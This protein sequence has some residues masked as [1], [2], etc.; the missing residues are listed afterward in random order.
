MRT[1]SFAARPPATPGNKPACA[2]SICSVAKTLPVSRSKTE[3]NASAPRANTFPLTITGCANITTSDSVSSILAFQSCFKGKSRDK[4][5]PPCAEV[6]PG[7][8]NPLFTTAF[9]RPASSAEAC[10]S[11]INVRRSESTSSRSPDRRTSLSAQP[12]SAN[13]QIISPASRTAE[14]KR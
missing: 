1:F 9:P 4:C 8:P 14:A 12:A 11:I 10:P 7:W 5:P 13:R 2:S 6:T 3:T